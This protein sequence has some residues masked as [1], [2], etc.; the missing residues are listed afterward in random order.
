VALDRKWSVDIAMLGLFREECIPPPIP[1][2]PDAHFRHF[3]RLDLQVSAWRMALLVVLLADW[4]DFA[5]KS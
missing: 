3:K 4:N 1:N 5:P 2:I